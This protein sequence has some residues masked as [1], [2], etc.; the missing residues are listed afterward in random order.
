MQRFV[1]FNHEPVLIN[2]LKNGDELAV[3]YWFKKYRAPLMKL[4][5][6]KLPTR[7]LAEEAVQETFVNC[8]RSLNLFKGESTLLT[9]MHSV[10]RHEI[11]D[12]Y[13][14]TYAKKFIRTIPLSEFLLDHECKDAHET[15]ELVGVVLKKMAAKSRE[16]LMKKYVD[17]C[18]TKELAMEL[19]QSEKAVESA[20]FRARREF[21]LLWVEY[22]K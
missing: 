16:L 4:A 11:A 1:G 20:L 10:L 2:A 17:N 15:A 14:K 22:A 19:G 9:F 7:Q 13:R 3:E 18:R 6:L 12:Y 21:R 8:L 5:L